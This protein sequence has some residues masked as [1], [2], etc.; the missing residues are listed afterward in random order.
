MPASVRRARPSIARLQAAL[1]GVVEQLRPDRLGIA[2]DDGVRLALRFLRQQRD[3]IAA[4]YNGHAAG[5]EGAGDLVGAQGREGLDADGDKVGR[6]VEGDVLHTVVVKT[7]LD[8]GRRQTGE[9]RHRQ[10]LHL[11]GA[12][13]GLVFLAADRR[14]DE[15]EAH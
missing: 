9:Q 13:V 12:H 11:P 2:D 7:H 1:A 8:I 5:T 4:E 10:R 3:V 6:L 14:I 15:G